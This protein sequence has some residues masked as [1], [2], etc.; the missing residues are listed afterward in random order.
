MQAFAAKH[1]LFFALST[2][3]LLF[4]LAFFRAEWQPLLIALRTHLFVVAFAVLLLAPLW[5]FARKRTKLSRAIAV[6]LGIA[7]FAALAVW[8]ATIHQYM[9]LYYRYRTLDVVELTELPVSDQER[10]PPLNSIYTIAK[11]KISE[12]ESPQRPDFVRVDD[13]YRFTPRDRAGLRHQASLRRRPRAVQHLR[14]LSGPRFLQPE[15][16]G[17]ALRGRERACSATATWRPP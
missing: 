15:P 10:I 1:K 6:T 11:H 3:V 13:A 12:T 16:C 7:I 4:G 9:A 17:S 14:H 8:G 2:L 5:L